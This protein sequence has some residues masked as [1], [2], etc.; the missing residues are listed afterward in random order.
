[1]SHGQSLLTPIF[2][3]KPETISALVNR[4]VVEQHIEE[5]S[6][7]WLQHV[8]AVSRPDYLL[9]DLTDLDGYIDANLEGIYLGNETAWEI[10]EALL[11]EDEEYIFPAAVLAIRRNNQAWQQRVLKAV[12]DDNVASFIGALGWVDYATVEPFL[13]QLIDDQK[14]FYH[15][16]ALSAYGLHRKMPPVDLRELLKT[17][18]PLLKRR[19]IRLIGELKCGEFRRDL[20]P[21]LIS[22]REE[23]RFWSAWAL[24]LIGERTT[25]IPVLTAFLYSDSDY[26]RQA[27]PI[28]LRITEHDQRR[29]MID[30]LIDGQRL[31]LAALAVGAAGYA[32]DIPWLIGIMARPELARLAGEAFSFITGI[33]LDY[34][35]LVLDDD[36]SDEDDSEETEEEGWLADYQQDLPLPDPRLINEWWR[37]YRSHYQSGVRYLAG[38]EVNEGN[39]YQV[40]STGLQRQRIAAALELALLAPENSFLE[41]QCRAKDRLRLN[42][43]SGGKHG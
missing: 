41:M 37:Q 7:Q 16:I 3:I 32:D 21:Y 20:H 29:E 33:D 1:M 12:N 22:E 2:G 36:L 6:F 23:Y 15:Y 11:E 27:V 35:D 10:C 39:L 8:S 30:R 19:T 42:I 40:I 18:I 25:V 13:K 9:D 24:A 31:H 17:D 4:D 43:L 14:P 28:A 26:A 34:D 5:V 38:K